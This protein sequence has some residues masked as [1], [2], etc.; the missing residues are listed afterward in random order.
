[1]V[2]VY[3]LLWSY[4]EN[5]TYYSQCRDY[6]TYLEDINQRRLQEG[7]NL[8]IT[9]VEKKT[10]VD[11]LKLDIDLSIV[12]EVNLKMSKLEM[13]SEVFNIIFDKD[14]VVRSIKS[15]YERDETE[16]IFSNASEKDVYSK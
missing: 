9:D 4:L 13:K 16:Q 15:T 1:M 12:A 10:K 6:L 2:R 5:E 14:L 8:V 11:S 7:A 3:H